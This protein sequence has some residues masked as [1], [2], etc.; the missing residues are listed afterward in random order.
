MPLA[1]IKIFRHAFQR[2]TAKV[3]SFRNDCLDSY[4]FAVVV[5]ARGAG[6]APEFFRLLGGLVMGGHFDAE[7]YLFDKCLAEIISKGRPIRRAERHGETPN[8]RSNPG[9]NPVCSV[10][11]N[12]AE[13]V[14]KV[15]SLCRDAQSALSSWH[16]LVLVRPIALL[17]LK[18]LTTHG[19]EPFAA[20]LLDPS[21]KAMHVEGVAAFADHCG[22]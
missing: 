7:V 14:V 8:S 17:P 6:F 10:G 18:L 19:T 12:D 1:T 21:E 22:C 20:V 4:S 5:S 9:C 16:G 13:V 3:L 15:F 11:G 2:R